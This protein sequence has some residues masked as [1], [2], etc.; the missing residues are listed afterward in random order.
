MSDD[1]VVI[2]HAF[3]PDEPSS[4]TSEVSSFLFFKNVK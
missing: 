4:N 2:V 3:Y 1:L